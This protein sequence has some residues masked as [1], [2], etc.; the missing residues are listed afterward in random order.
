MQKS[1]RILPITS[2]NQ[3]EQQVLYSAKMYIKRTAEKL[4]W[5]R[6]VKSK[7]KVMQHFKD[8]PVLKIDATV[9]TPAE[10]MWKSKLWNKSR[11]EIADS[12]VDPTT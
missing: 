2:K 3:S 9:N 7:P 12:Y 6:A 11:K 4:L 1:M 5:V 8:D 10:S